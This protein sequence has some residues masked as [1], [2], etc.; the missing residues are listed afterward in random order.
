MIQSG[1]PAVSK[2][3]PYSNIIVC[4]TGDVRFFFL[5]LRLPSGGS[6]YICICVE[7]LTIYKKQ[8]LKNETNL[9][10]HSQKNDSAVMPEGRDSDSVCKN[11]YMCY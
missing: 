8:N 10:C 5:I 11:D 4:I 2:N 7:I 6:Y 1:V 3:F 9:Q